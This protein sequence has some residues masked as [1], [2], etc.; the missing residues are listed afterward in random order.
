[1]NRKILSF[2]IVFM[3]FSTII[4]AL[5]E[6]IRV[7]SN[8]YKISDYDRSIEIYHT[9]R[10]SS[11]LTSVWGYTIH[12]NIYYKN[13]AKSC[14][15]V[16][17]LNT[18]A[19]DSDADFNSVVFYDKSE[20]NR[21]VL[22]LNKSIDREKLFRDS[23]ATIHLRRLQNIV[24]KQ[25]RLSDYEIDSLIKLIED[26]KFTIYIRFMRGSDYY[27]LNK[28]DFDKRQAKALYSLLKFYKDIKN[29]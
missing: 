2:I 9:E 16:F 22:N 8:L 20:S 19:N 21:F 4:F 15:L 23:D 5:D 17:D 29:K 3:S 18:E 12:T 14:Y 24:R 13:N 6:N 7:P 11:T 1:M 25:H 28:Y 26:S 10:G 27:Y